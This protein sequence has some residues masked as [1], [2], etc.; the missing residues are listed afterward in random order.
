MM[1]APRVKQERR[2]AIIKKGHTHLLCTHTDTHKHTGTHSIQTVA[3]FRERETVCEMLE[4][5]GANQKKN[6]KVLEHST[7]QE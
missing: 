2:P 6:T 3:D 4:Q 1:R 5:S 7:S